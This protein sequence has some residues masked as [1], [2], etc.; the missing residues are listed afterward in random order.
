[1]AESKFLRWQDQDGDGLIDK[2][3]DRVDT[4]PNCG[5]LACSPNPLAIVPDWK[6]RNVNYP[7]LNKKSCEYWITVV[8]KHTSVGDENEKFK[9]FA[10]EAARGL[11]AFYN[12]NDEQPNVNKVIENFKNE[13][14]FLAPRNKS[15]LK[16]LYSIPY[17]IFESIGPANPQEDEEEDEPGWMREKYDAAAMS[18]KMIRIRK[19]LNLYDRYLK[20]YRAI[21]GGNL[22]FVDDGRIFNLGDYGDSAIFSSSVMSDMLD[23]LDSFLSGLGMD[24]PGVGGWFDNFWG[25]DQ[26]V[27]DIEFTTDNY[28]LKKIR[29]WTTSCGEKPFVIHGK[30]LKPLKAQPAWRDQ[31]AIAYLMQLFKMEAAA[32]ARVQIPWQEFLIEFTYPKIYTTLGDGMGTEPG[33]ETVGSCIAEAL[34]N[35]M[36]ELGQDIMDEVFGIG[37]AVAYAFRNS[38]CRTNLKDVQ[39]DLKQMGL[40]YAEFMESGSGKHWS[41]AEE[42]LAKKDKTGMIG[43]ATMQAFKELNQTDNI[44]TKVCGNMLAKGIGIGPGIKRVDDVFEFGLEPLKQCGLFELLMGAIRCLLGGLSMEEAMAAM[45]KSALS[46][47]SIEN[48]GDLFIGLPVEDQIALDAMVKKK[49]EEG[50]IFGEGSTGQQVSDAIDGKL[51]WKKPWNNKEVIDRERKNQQES[52][53]GGMGSTFREPPRSH[54]QSTRRTLAQQFS[55]ASS[56]LDTDTIMGAYVEALLQHYKENLLGL[57]DKLNRF[58]GARIIATVIATLDCPRAPLFNPNLM[59]WIMSHLQFPCSGINDIRTLRFENPGKFWPW[60]TDML[61][62]LWR[63][64]KWAIIQAL[65]NILILILIKLCEIIGDAI[66]KALEFAGTIAASMPAILTGRKLLSEVIKESICGPDADDETIDNTIVELLGTFGVGGEAFAN[67][68]KI[69]QFGE[70]LAST[71]TKTELAGAFLGDPSTEFLEV[72]DQMIEFEYPEYRSA[73]SGPRA[74]GTMLKNMGNLM[75]MEYREQLANLTSAIDEDDMM[76]ANPTLCATTEQIDRF[77]ELRCELLEG[78][79]TKEQCDAMYEDMRTGWLEDLGDISNIL[80]TGLPAYIS[81]QMPKMQS[82]PGCDDG[83]LPS[84]L[85]IEMDT[86]IGTALQNDLE[87]LKIDYSTDMLGNG[88]FWNSDASWGFVNEVLSDTEGNPLSTHHRKAFNNNDYVHFATNIP[89]GGSPAMGFFSFL[90]RNHGFST[91]HGQFPTYVGSWMMRQ[92][93]NAG[94]GYYDYD[95]FQPSGGDLSKGGYDLEKGLGGK[96]FVYNSH[97]LRRGN[98]KYYVD[99]ADVQVNTF[100][101]MDMSLLSLPDF[102]YG[103][104]YG[105]NWSREKVVVTQASRKGKK[106]SSVPGLYRGDIVFDFKDNAAGMRTTGGRGMDGDQ[107]FRGSSWFGSPPESEWSY[108][109]EVNAFFGDIEEIKEPIYFT[110]KEMPGGTGVASET[111]T[112][113]GYEGTGKYANRLSDNIRVVID[114]KINTDAEIESPLAELVGSDFEKSKAFV[115]AQYIPWLAA[116]PLVGWALES[117]INLLVLPFSFLF[118]ANPDIGN[119]SAGLGSVYYFKKYAFR[120]EDDGLDG[121]RDGEGGPINPSRYDHFAKCFQNVEDHQPQVALLADMIGGSPASVKPLH[122]NTMTELFKNFAAIIGTN[123]N[124]FLYG[125]E[126]DYLMQS[127]AEYVAPP[128]YS[129]EGEPYEGIQIWDE[130]DEEYRSPR[131][132]DMIMGMSSDQYRNYKRGTPNK[133]RVIYLDPK[134]FGGSYLSPNIYVKHIDFDGWLGMV[135]VFFPELS[136]CKPSRT[137]MVDFGDLQARVNALK[138]RIPEDIRLRQDEECAVEVP[139]NRVLNSSAKA[140]IFALIDAAIRIF[141]STGF[142]KA[143]GTFSAIAPKFPDNYSSLWSAYIVEIMEDNFKNAQP[144]FW[145]WF[146]SFK[147]EEFWFGFLEMCVTYY[148]WM[149]DEGE[150]VDPPGAVLEALGRLNTLQAVYPFAYWSNYKDKYDHKVIGLWEAKKLGKA[151]WFEGIMSYREGENFETI[152]DVE[153]DAKMIMAELV[154]IQMNWCAEKLLEN[155]ADEGFVPSIYDLDYWVFSDQ[156]NGSSLQYRGHEIIEK[157]LSLPNED[158]PNFPGP[159]YTSG[160]EFRVVRDDDPDDAYVL[161]DV[162]AGQYHLHRDED[163]ELI[164]MAGEEHDPEGGQDL[165]RPIASKVIVGTEA[166]IKVSGGGDRTDVSYEKMFVPLG[167][168]PELGT[169]PGEGKQFTLEKFISIN[170]VRMAPSAAIEQIKSNPNQNSLL[171]EVYPGDMRLVEAPSRDGGT[172]GRIV[173]ID[174]N[175]GVQYGLVFSYNGSPITSVQVDALDLPLSATAPFERDSKLLLC[176][177]KQ[178]K[179]DTRYKLLLHYVFPLKKITALLAV[180]NDM[181]FLSSIGEVTVGRG[182][183]KRW[184]PTGPFAEAFLKPFGV[185]VPGQRN[186]DDWIGNNLESIKA[187]PGRIGFIALNSETHWVPDPNWFEFDEEYECEFVW[188][189]QGKSATGGNEGWQHYRDRQPGFFNIDSWWVKEWD[190][191]DRQLLRNSTSRIKR[192]FKAYYYSRDWTPADAGSSGAGDLWLKNLKAAIMPSPGK[193]ILPWWRKSKIRGNPYDKDGNL[194]D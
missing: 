175:L 81:S 48:F 20:V 47:M 9:E 192:L 87:M 4:L 125:A 3:D 158:D 65:I 88:N 151:G 129:N 154:S 16:L 141:A 66:C 83:I 15:R 12:K 155:L 130:E 1:M 75:P 194:C 53:P 174:G 64:I 114:E 21:D 56:G 67:R 97:N 166:T 156:C 5:D 147:D 49:L 31:T 149:L 111:S 132:S 45:L 38:V 161:G 135:Q 58:P 62:N 160:A 169:A 133:A 170:G 164:F 178:L 93:L 30:R 105:I 25:I 163:G 50:D 82:S 110:K 181:G 63:I 55:E 193:G 36:K 40:E 131:N 69:L 92:F 77:K 17:D 144:A 117:L 34:N 128:G 43:M 98:K 44:F 32:S 29:V 22:F 119:A 76:P 72:V 150:I 177:L 11:L 171:S 183:Y 78:R 10:E 18:T 52:G 124:G 113:I 95:A 191:W 121:L 126:Y 136:P 139:F 19:T 176:L 153:E 182:D 28:N 59:D 168:V 101:S 184:I 102:G 37:D 86:V 61:R 159:Y 26:S 57:L 85:P 27:T 103:V 8:T 115:L 142:M 24:L 100:L 180:Y 143:I 6:K 99:F 118:R 94:Q 152:M 162:Y 71:T 35:E 70:D 186:R 84:G 146:N 90:Q 2:C 140:G 96:S 134:Q 145:E 127:D 33:E 107:K 179:E 165:L 173:G 188:V 138:P 157:A 116:V 23:G 122:D 167:D 54:A 42:G 89:N 74:I 104:T 137:D 91:Q 108:G 51:E 14:Y 13:K 68:D 148:A 7:F 60:V 172:T 39:T 123:T 79:A 187:K 189:D 112:I 109:Y 80:Q 185:E 106:D 41:E 120:A 46:A 190:E 73:L